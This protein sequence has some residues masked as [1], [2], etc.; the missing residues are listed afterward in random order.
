MPRGRIEITQACELNILNYFKI[1]IMGAITIKQVKKHIGRSPKF[2][3]N[4]NFVR[5]IFVVPL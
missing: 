1:I 5:Y 3:K 2:N 4:N